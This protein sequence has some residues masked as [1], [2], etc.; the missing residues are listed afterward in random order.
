VPSPR[1]S[2]IVAALGL[3]LALGG[4]AAFLS[5][6]VPIAASMG[7]ILAGWAI[8][9]AGAAVGVTGLVRTWQSRP[10]NAPPGWY[11]DPESDSGQR[12]WDGKGWT[13]HRA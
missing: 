4:T 7:L 6:D 9:I 1:T 2:F 10:R 13:N 5:P 12:Y 8:A 3:V 11:P